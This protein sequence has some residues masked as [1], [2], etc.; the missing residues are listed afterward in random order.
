MIKIIK[1][2]KRRGKM[3]KKNIIRDSVTQAIIQSLSH[4]IRVPEG[5]ETENGIEKILAST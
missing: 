1:I 3:K 5:E 2:K 4:T